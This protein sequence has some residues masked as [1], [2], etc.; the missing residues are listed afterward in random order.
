MNAEQADRMKLET[1][2]AALVMAQAQNWRGMKE[3]I[4]ACGA[5]QYHHSLF[6]G[7]RAAA[8]TAQYGTVHVHASR[9]DVFDRPLVATLEQFPEL[10]ARMEEAADECVTE[11]SWIVR[12]LAGRVHDAERC[13]AEWLASQA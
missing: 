2:R 11:L 10:A 8:L 12:S 3:T 5:A 9:C 13:R 4:R 7:V 1:A 6:D